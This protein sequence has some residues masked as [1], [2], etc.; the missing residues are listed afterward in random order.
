MRGGGIELL[1]DPRHLET[2]KY[3]SDGGLATRTDI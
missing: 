2:G 3:G 1:A